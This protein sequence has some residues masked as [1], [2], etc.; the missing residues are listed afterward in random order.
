MLKEK[1][2]EWVSR[3]RSGKY[4]QGKG[5]LRNENNKFCCL[6]VLSELAVEDGILERESYSYFSKK[7]DMSFSVSL[8]DEVKN[9]YNMKSIGGFCSLGKE[10]LAEMNDRG[11]SFSEIADYIEAN[12][13]KV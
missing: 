2:I 6:G 4:Q 11:K 12:W 1:A 10:C 13:E 5:C 9:K 7:D 3:L 8:A